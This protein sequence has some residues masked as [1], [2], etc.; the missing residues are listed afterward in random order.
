MFTSLPRKFYG[1]LFAPFVLPLIFAVI[2]KATDNHPPVA[3]PDHYAVHRSFSTPTDFQPYGV[4]R[5]DSAT[6]GL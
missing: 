5:N 6:D 4:L 2:P 1:L 3:N